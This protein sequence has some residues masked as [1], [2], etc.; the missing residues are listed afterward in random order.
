MYELLITIHV[1]AA[2]IWVGGGTMV[3]ILG[4]R[5]L[6]A[7][8]SARS[9]DFSRQANWVGSRL[10]APLALILIVAGSLLVEEAGYEFNQLWIILAQ[11]AWIFS[12]LL[13]VAY[14]GR[15]QRKLEAIVAERGADDPAVF[16]ATRSVLT[17]NAIETLV[18]LLVVIDMT[19]KPG[20]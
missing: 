5:T 3:Q 16:A 10:F 19:V 6:A 18:L 2:V 8:D 14:Y 15:Q 17:V 11:I 7:G 12:F 1:L 4:H 20:V 13:G 9:L